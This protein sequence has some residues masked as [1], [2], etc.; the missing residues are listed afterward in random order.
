[1]CKGAKLLQYGSG[2]K[3]EGGCEMRMHQRAN[4]NEESRYRML[5]MAVST[6]SEEYSVNM[7]TLRILSHPCTFLCC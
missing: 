6:E 1:M 7:Q 3:F 5:H 4:S 2:D